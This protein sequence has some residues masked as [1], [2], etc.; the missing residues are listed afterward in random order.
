MSRTG[1]RLTLRAREARYGDVS[2]SRFQGLYEQSP[3]LAVC[4]LLTGLGSVGF[5]GTLGFVSTELLVDGAVQVSPYV[6]FTVA[7]IAAINGIAVVRAYFRLF[8]GARH[9]S[10]ISLNIGPRERLAVLTLSALILGGGIF[11]QVHIA[12]R[13]RAAG[14]VLLRRG[15]RDSALPHDDEDAT[16]WIQPEKTAPPV[17]Q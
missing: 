10:T 14:E 6:G 5:P 7:L 8:T 13:Y 3:A 2:L 17:E 12:S 1:L 11:P 16:V 15:A 9:A 4:F